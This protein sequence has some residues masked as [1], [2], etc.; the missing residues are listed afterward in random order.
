MVAL[1]VSHSSTDDAVT[2]QISRRLEAVGFAALFLDF[3]PVRGI[4]VGRSWERELYSQLRKTDGVVFLASRSSTTSRWCFAEL[5]L[6][7]SLGKPIFPLRLQRDATL[8]LLADTQW[9]DVGDKE[10]G[11]AALLAGLRMAGLDPA[12]S[13]A[14]DPLRSPYPGL[15][16]FTSEDA[17]VFFGRDREIRDLEQLLEPTLQRGAGRFVGIVGP[18]GSGKS[19]LLHAGLLP[20]LQR[21]PERWIVLPSVVPGRQPTRNLARAIAKALATGDSP[22]TPDELEAALRR[23]PPLLVELAGQLIRGPHRRQNVLVVIDQFEE[24]VTLTGPREQ[25]EFLALLRGAMDEDSP[26][27]AVATIRS[28]FLSTAPDRAGFAEAVEDCVIV[29]PFSPTRLPEII[30]RPAQRAGLDFEPGLVE[31]MV[32]DAAGGDALPLLAY[33]LRELYER[34]GPDGRIGSTD[35]DS[36]GGVVGALQRRADQLVADLTRRGHGDHILPT[37]LKLATIDGESEPIRRRLPRAELTP[38]ED[39]VVSAFV[40]ARLLTSGIAGMAGATVEVAHE[41]LLRRWPPLRAAIEES[42][43]SLRMRSDL[44][45]LAADWDR[46]SG[47]ESYLLRGARLANAD[48]WAAGHRDEI[49]GLEHRFL[50]ASRSLAS[51]ELDSARRT[52]RRLRLLAG[53][54]A[55]LLILALTA[56]VVAAAQNRSAQANS[57]INFSR[58]LAAQADRLADSQPETAIL[59]G[60][61]SLSVARHDDPAPQPASGLI[62]AL[63]RR[64]HASRPLTGHT[65]EVSSVAFEPD[66]KLL[67]SAGQDRTVRLWA[68]PSGD[69]YPKTLAARTTELSGV[70]FSA[71]GALLAAGGDDGQVRLWEVPSG[72][73]LPPLAGHKGEVY[74]VAF[75]RDGRLLASSG[76]DGT[77]RLWD[78]PSMRQHGAPLTGHTDAVY[79]IAFSPD[80]RL[81]ASAGWDHTVRMWHIPSG[82]EYLAPLAHPDEVQSVAFNPQGSSLAS[83]SVDHV[84]R[85][86][87]VRSGKQQ[88]SLTGHTGEVQSVDFSPDGKLLASTDT[89]G[90]VRLWDVAGR[91]PHGLPL[92]GHSASVREVAFSPDGRTLATGSWDRTLRLWDVDETP[93][94]SR[95]LVG[96]TGEVYGVA[97]SPDGKMVATA[98]ADDTVRLWD[99][100]SGQE[101]GRPL[102]GHTDDVYAVAFSP[103]GK[104]VA[105]GGLDNTVRLWDLASRQQRGPPL[106]GHTDWIDS[107]AFSP[108]GRTLASSSADYDVRLWDVMAGRPLGKPLHGHTQEVYDVTFSPDGRLIASASVDRTVRLWDVAERR[109]HGKPLIGHTNWVTSVAFSPNGKLLAS[110]SQDQSIRIWDAA[111]GRSMGPAMVGHTAEV[112]DVAFSRDST[113]VA[114]ASAD[115]TVR[116]WDTAGH[117]LGQPLTGHTGTVSAVAFSPRGD[118]LATA[119]EDRTARLWNPDFSEWLIYGCKIVGRNLSKTDWD[120]FA[121]QHPYERT[122]PD[123]PSG[124]DAPQNAP[125]ARY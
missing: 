15:E 112:R 16:A 31:R 12:D 100:A 11:V 71:K 90:P 118:L 105:S 55:V 98:S 65:G 9:I 33:T 114:S 104:L 106:E 89:D 109:P 67:A 6:A 79:R 30:Q 60:L 61:Q 19:S 66:G 27:W 58:Q 14:W 83:A 108:D 121:G 73:P 63:A 52:N 39:A 117:P 115:Q 122:C 35:Y 41:A 44:E 123:L 37:L 116:L 70:A 48:E 74:G 46:A 92:T 125:A 22:R 84:I 85:L 62:T 53:G 8:E 21:R 124:P 80:G 57:R 24:L 86:W 96:H 2:L 34:S 38:D 113:R 59:L 110:G 51:R 101:N 45:R 42:R 103:D 91:R 102:L 29:E 64:T 93:S 50:E 88:G 81:L 68:M 69:P 5:C 23:G 111:T 119:S 56:S 40:D 47:D 75:S 10:Q 97:F 25:Q 13:V 77:V 4:P 1:F 49:A 87:D 7:R 3:D 120:R 17:A 72:R 94:I 95:P 76:S 36:V 28:E 107:V 20:R 32:S 26:L 43:A 78:L 99:T 82:K 18:S 54:L